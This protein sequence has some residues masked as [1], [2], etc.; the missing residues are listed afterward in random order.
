MIQNTL[1][2]GNKE[3][4]QGRGTI[5]EQIL[6]GSEG[7]SHADIWGKSV[8]SGKQQVQRP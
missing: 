3:R 6:E 1:K 4:Q 5:L 7:T 2:I 8:L